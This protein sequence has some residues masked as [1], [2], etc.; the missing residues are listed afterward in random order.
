MRIMPRF[1]VATALRPASNA[2]ACVYYNA[3]RFY[4][5]CRTT[6]SIFDNGQKI[7]WLDNV[8]ADS[9]GVLRFACIATNYADIAYEY[10]DIVTYAN[11]WGNF[12]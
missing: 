8:Y 11:P 2:Q 4:G 6:A 1:S 7:C 3:Y 9:G 5:D 12:A 10:G